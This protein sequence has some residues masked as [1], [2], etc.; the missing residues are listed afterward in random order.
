MALLRDEDVTQ[1]KELFG[2]LT[3]DVTLVHFTQKTSMLVV[4]GALE[5]PS[6]R[7]TQQILEELVDVSDRLTLEIHDF[8]GES[9]VAAE[10]GID[11]IPATVVRGSSTAGRVRFFG[12]PAGYEFGS[13]IEDIL[14]AGGGPSGL[15]PE[16]TEALAGLTGDVDIKVFVS[17]T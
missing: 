13:L 7:D 12:L 9:D 1:L 6:C 4:P 5:C 11:K 14:D 17:P 16:S 2:S 10:W 3:G 8:A 15:E